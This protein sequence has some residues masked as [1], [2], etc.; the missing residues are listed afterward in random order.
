VGDTE[1]E[2]MLEQK[3]RNYRIRSV[4]ILEFKKWGGGTA[5]SKKK[6]GANINVYLA[7]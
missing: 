2:R 3:N 7:C 1:E 4:A 6:Y 5:G